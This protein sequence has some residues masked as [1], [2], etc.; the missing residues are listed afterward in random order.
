M[1]KDKR[2]KKRDPI[3]EARKAAHRAKSNPDF[4]ATRHDDDDDNHGE[5]IKHG[6]R[7]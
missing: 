5:R 1:S 4:Y 3:R 7:K 2:H 6:K